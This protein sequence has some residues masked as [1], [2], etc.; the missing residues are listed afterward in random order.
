MSGHE[1]PMFVEDVVRK[2]LINVIR[3]FR[4]LPDD[5]LIIVESESLESIHQHNAVAK[6]IATLGELR[7]D[8]V[9]S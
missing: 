7:E 6:R 2:I 3:K 5:S 8:L 4:G 9:S 1:N